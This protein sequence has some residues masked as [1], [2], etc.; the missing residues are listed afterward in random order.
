MLLHIA[1]KQDQILGEQLGFF[2]VHRRL[3]VCGHEFGS[4]PVLQ[5]FTET[6]LQIFGYLEQITCVVGH[7]L[8]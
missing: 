6:P 8:E 7:P 4:E 2:P 1:Q 3:S 5:G